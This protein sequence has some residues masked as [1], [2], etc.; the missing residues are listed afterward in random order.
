MTPRNK[1]IFLL[2]GFLIMVLISYQLSISRTIS[3]KK[4]INLLKEQNINS[5]NL[6][7]LSANLGQREKFADSVLKKNNIKGVSIQ[8]NLLE[9]LNSEALKGDFIITQFTEPHHIIENEVAITSYQFGLKGSFRSIENVLYQ[10]EQEYNFGQVSH[11]RF[12]KKRDY[13]RGKDYLEC[14]VIV[15]SFV[16]E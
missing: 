14:S 1:N 13:R 7:R 4:D 3:L 5:D 2:V 12:E 9:L 16:S 8:N 15:E 6:A 11:V 10:L